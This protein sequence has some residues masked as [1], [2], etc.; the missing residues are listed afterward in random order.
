MDAVL[1]H[2]FPRTR[3]F[4][5]WDPV[6]PLPSTSRTPCLPASLIWLG[7]FP[8]KGSIQLPAHFCKRGRQAGGLR[9]H[10]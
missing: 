4:A 8:Q 1:P 2:L 3:L 9:G 6:T 5:P 7:P 10:R